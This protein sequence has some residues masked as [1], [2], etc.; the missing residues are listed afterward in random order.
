MFLVTCLYKPGAAEARMAV[1]APHIEYMIAAMPQT[2]FGGPLLADDGETATGLV[3]ILDLPDRAA[4]DRF[5]QNEP[6]FT[7]D[8]FERVEI[9][10]CR[11][12]VPEPEVGFLA[13]ELER[14]KAA[15]AG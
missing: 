6:Y 2:V 14:Q 15:D 5:V 12:F 13:A 7:N 1:R 8:L 3:V 4:A 11:Q 10:E 9:H